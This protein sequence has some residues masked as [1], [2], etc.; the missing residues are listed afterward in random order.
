MS[1]SWEKTVCAG[2]LA[3]ICGSSLAGNASTGL[4]SWLLETLTWSGP[5]FAAP[6]GET[7]G[8]LCY[9]GKGRRT[10]SVLEDRQRVHHQR[11]ADEVHVLA[12]VA[13]TVGPAQPH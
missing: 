1:K 13:D 11:I 9:R 6:G 2:Q 7:W 10:P 8:S 5:R 12:G 3:P 4:L